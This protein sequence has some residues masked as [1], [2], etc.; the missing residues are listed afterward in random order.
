MI[1]YFAIG[2]THALLLLAFLR[3]LGRDDLDRDPVDER[4]VNGRAADPVYRERPEIANGANA[5]DAAQ[6]RRG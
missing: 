2:L 3:I 4:K 6:E 1:D 5:A